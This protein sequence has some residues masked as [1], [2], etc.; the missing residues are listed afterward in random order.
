[1]AGSRFQI[2][3]PSQLAELSVIEVPDKEA[4]LRERMLQL[5][6]IWTSYDPP[7]GAEYDVEG[8]EFDPIKINQEVTTYFDLML[9]D[10]I[11]Q[12]ARAT[13]LAF[14]SDHDI[15]VVASRYPGGV[16]R[17]AGE[18]DE[19]YRMRVWLSANAFTSAG[20]E[21]AYVFHAMTAQPVLSHVTATKIR[22]RPNDV[23]VIVTCLRR[24]EPGWLEPV[25]RGSVLDIL[26]DDQLVPTALELQAVRVALNA[27]GVRPLTDVIV[28]RAPKIVMADYEI[29]VWLYP[30]GIMSSIL[31]NIA[32]NL[33]K[34]LANQ[35]L[36][37]HEHS[38]NAIHAAVKVGGVHSATVDRP[39]LDVFA[40]PT[41]IVKVNTVRVSVVGRAE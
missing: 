7:Y 35:R 15:D 29:R 31:G 23:Q 27:K 22:P 21:E 14:S 37:G 33:V 6:A 10:R 17:L 26:V 9:R 20:V 18:S 1:M 38:L 30:T 19:R 11:N 5:K 8:L 24:P 4:I 36:L 16:P 32:D 41:Q 40:D 28:V 25:V 13:T 2:I 34:L 12:A 39:A 3:D